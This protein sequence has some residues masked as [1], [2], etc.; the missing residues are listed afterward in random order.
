MGAKKCQVFLEKDCLV[1]VP[2]FLRSIAPYVEIKFGDQY[3]WK[4]ILTGV[5]RI[6]IIF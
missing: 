6:Y 2:E 3:C 5:D 1:E 4:G